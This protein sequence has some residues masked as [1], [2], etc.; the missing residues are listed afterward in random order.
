[1]HHKNLRRGL[2]ILIF[3]IVAITGYLYIDNPFIAPK[4][5][6]RDEQYVTGGLIK[7][8][9]SYLSISVNG[10]KYT[11][12]YST[13][14]AHDKKVKKF[15]ISSE[16]KTSSGLGADMYISAPNGPDL[17]MDTGSQVHKI[18]SIDAQIDSS[19]G[20]NGLPENHWMISY[21]YTDEYTGVLRGGFMPVP[22]LGEMAK[23]GHIGRSTKDQTV[24]VD[25]YVKVTDTMPAGEY[26]T[27]LDF[28]VIARYVSNS[29]L[30][31]RGYE[32]RQ[33]FNQ[34]MFN[35][36]YQNKPKVFKKSLVKPSSDQD[37][38][39]C[40]NTESSVDYVPVISDAPI[41]CWISQTDRAIYWYSEA[42]TVNIDIKHDYSFSYLDLD[43]LDF[44]GISMKVRTLPASWFVRSDTGAKYK[45]T[46]P[47][48]V[49]Y[50]PDSMEG[51]FRGVKLENLSFEN[52]E[53]KQP[54]KNIK[55]LFQG[56][57]IDK[58][59]LGNMVFS[60]VEDMEAMF[61]RSQISDTEINK[62]ISKIN[63]SK[64]TNMAQ[65]FAWSKVE[66]LDLSHLDTSNVTTMSGM[67]QSAWYLK[68][69][70]LINFNTKKVKD[71]ADMFVT[72]GYYAEDFTLDLSSFDTSSVEKFNGIFHRI[73]NL[74]TII[75]SDKF[76]VKSGATTENMFKDDPKLTGGAGTIFND[77]HI[78][79][80]YARIDNPAA[81]NPGYFTAKTP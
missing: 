47:D 75:T 23:I 40:H 62:V 31:M 78:D 21:G 25:G 76:V 1:M 30:F 46:W 43:E 29:A 45:I 15:S 24:I 9:D 11:Q 33:L 13:T 65:V 10:S 41:D 61:M 19:I 18:P 16:M 37:V 44:S 57:T 12:Q 56:A 66:N 38:F 70:N 69:L 27:N 39:P 64:V 7:N 72:A 48:K 34:K 42:A 59:N 52:F 49:I 17:V 50:Y 5:N 54:I 53:F 2:K 6:A 20:V 80:E 79:G 36:P 51:L 77:S 71:M 67:F 35:I 74:K 14:E 68:N 28:T 63:T 60:D 4:A 55:R 22:K 32:L 58:I 26:S 73:P 3:C 8:G 81:G